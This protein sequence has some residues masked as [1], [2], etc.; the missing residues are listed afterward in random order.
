M[1]ENQQIEW[2]E[3][4]RD[5]HLKGICAFANTRGGVLE[6]GRNDNGEIVKVTNAT[7][8]MEDIPNKIRDM[9]GIVVAVDWP[10]KNGEK[11]IRIEIEPQPY[12]VSYKGRYYTRIGSTTQELRGNALDHFLLRKTGKRWDAVPVPD[13]ALEDLEHQ[14]IERFRERAVRSQRL[15]RDVMTEDDAVLLEKLHLMDG[16]YLKRAAVLLFHPDPEVIVTGA[17]IQIGYFESDSEVRY[18]DEIHGDLLTQ[19]DRTLDLLLTK[20]LKAWISYEG[21]QRVETYP[22]PEDALREALIN[23]VAHKDYSSGAPIQIRVY[24]DRTSFWNNGRLPNGWTENDLISEHASEP[25]NPDVAYTLFRAGMIEKWGRGIRKMQDAC[26]SHGIPGPLLRFEKTGLRVTFEHLSPIGRKL[27]PGPQGEML[28]RDTLRLLRRIF[29]FDEEA[30]IGKLRQQRRGTQFGFDI[31]L[32]ACFAANNENVRCHVECKSFDKE[33]RFGELLEKLHDAEREQPNLD[34]WILIAPRARLGNGSNGSVGEQISE[35]KF[36]FTIQLWTADEGVRS[37][38]GLEPDVYDHWIDHPPDEPHPR[39]WNAE[40]REAVRQRWLA[41]LRPPL[42]LPSVWANYVTDSRQKALFIENDDEKDLMALWMQNQYISL[43]AL[44]AGGVPLPG[45]LERSVLD[46]LRL[47][48][49]PRVAIVLGDFGDGKSAFTYMFS[50]T[51]LEQFRENPADGWLPVRFPLR[52]FSRPSTSAR[53]FLRDRLEE[54]SSN[55]AEWNGIVEEKNVLVILDGMDEMT[56]EL[57]DEAVRKNAIDLLLDC[58]NREFRRVKKILITCRKSFFENLGQR[59]YVDDKLEGPEILTI[60]P[61]DKSRVYGK[62]EERITPEQR[63][64]LHSLRQM[65]DPIGLARK[66]LFFR[67]LLNT[68]A[69]ASDPEDLSSETA[70]YEGYV[71]RCLERKYEYLETDGQN[72]KRDE[73]IAGTLGILQRMAMEMHRTGRNYICLHRLAGLSVDER[74]IASRLWEEAKDKSDETDAVRRIG[75]RSL[76]TNVTADV[77][78]KDAKKWPVE[79]CHRSVWEYFL[80]AGIE[81][82]LREGMVDALQVLFD[83]FIGPEVLR[84]TVDLMQRREHDYRDTLRQL[85]NLNRKGGYDTL[86]EEE[87]KRRSR[88]GTTAVTL[89][90]QWSGELPGENLEPDAAG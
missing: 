19:I 83:T 67:M 79:F 43:G 44:D 85:A 68:L 25:Y 35:Q 63:P 41:K 34:H 47:R 33:I 89:L 36:P 52:Y 8:L 60:Q 64:I 28:E 87:Q 50:R 55:I 27:S 42:R 15:G 4:W 76:L 86:T 58:C 78:V 48:E 65:H 49:K 70:I 18:H 77:D 14:V 75:V 88:S 13:V 20:Y 84:F 30:E 5:D 16:A 62:L 57:T 59:E 81:A 46:W 26:E 73:L 17:F 1:I 61:F 54:I 53:E 3:S 31:K 23:A 22:A 7:K 90:Y 2:K 56:Q 37:L 32:E 69:D 71:R 21:I 80:A 38:F 10:G 66:P 24:D 82:A 29:A 12:P 74:E 39:D 11:V 6:I 72:R 45:G 9:L 40:K 51:L